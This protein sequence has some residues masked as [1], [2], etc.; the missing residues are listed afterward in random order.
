V[1]QKAEWGERRL[2]LSRLSLQPN[3]LQEK[4][5]QDDHRLRLVAGG[6]RAGKSVVS[7]LD[8]VSRLPWGETYWLVGPDYTLP[9]AEFEY[10]EQFLWE[11]GALEKTKVHKPKEGPWQLTTKTGQKVTTR[12]SA[13]V[14]KLSAL[15]VDGV[16]MSEAGQQ[17]YAAALKCI[18]RISQS[19]GFLLLSGTFESSEDWYS[20]TFRDWCAEGAEGQAFSLPA[21]DNHHV[22]PGGRNDPE[23]L[24]LE[25]LYASIPGYFDQKC[26]AI[27]GAP[28]GV[29]FR[30]FSFRRHVTEECVFDARRPVYLAV[31]PAAGGPSAYCVAAC[32]FIPDPSP[33]EGDPIDF[34]HV[35]DAVYAPAAQFEDLFTL[36]EDK[37]WWPYVRGGA[38]DVEAPDERKRWH[39]F[40]GV[41]LAA[42]KIPVAEGERRL[43]TFL[44]YSEGRLPHLLFS[45]DIPPP[46][47]AEFTQYRTPVKEA[48]ELE[49]KSPGVVAGRRG[50][51]HLLSAL[52]YLLYIR[53][54]P[55]KG[56]SLPHPTVRGAWERLREALQGH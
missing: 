35:I 40:L 47:L 39:R 3:S 8:L 55:V 24:R 56:M 54:G 11:L 43:H 13:D 51:D 23:I 28:L 44:Y 17:T 31:D 48:G 42:K 34:C 49:K 5:L 30:E 38:I 37:V 21:W 20:S 33:L 52:W 14:Q 7:S 45:P 12:A 53:Y 50:P 2:I 25:R 18:G 36:L 1:W 6:E 41:P 16:I 19:R 10:V 29:I 46:A 27:P 4:I 26:G 32:Q 9:R 15:S 22:Y